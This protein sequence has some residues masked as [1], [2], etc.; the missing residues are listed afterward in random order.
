M[1]IA[2]AFLVPNPTR[3]GG[4]YFLLLLMRLAG[5]LA[6]PLP[7]RKP[8]CF[9]I[10]AVERPRAPVEQELLPIAIMLI[11]PTISSHMAVRFNTNISLDR[12]I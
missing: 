6:F 11:Q 3:V 2:F 12:L 7:G 9:L 5:A 10:W 1:S 8:V 4:A